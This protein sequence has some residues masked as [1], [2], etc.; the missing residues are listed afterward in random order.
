MGPAGRPGSFPR[1]RHPCLRAA[2][3][4]RRCPL[5]TGTPTWFES[6]SWCEDPPAELLSSLKPRRLMREGWVRRDLGC[7][8]ML[9]DPAYQV[10]DGHPFLRHAVPIANGHGSIFE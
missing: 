2:T 4:W 3:A 7:F 5:R 9:L 8:D 6:G 1:T 10:G